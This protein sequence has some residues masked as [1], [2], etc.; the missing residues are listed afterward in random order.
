MEPGKEGDCG[1]AHR[2]NP[3]KFP[4]DLQTDKNGRGFSKMTKTLTPELWEAM[5]ELE[6]FVYHAA[7]YWQS[8]WSLDSKDAHQRYHIVFS[9]HNWWYV[10]TREAYFLAA[11]LSL[12]KFFERNAHSVNIW[13]LVETLS[14]D[15][16][17]IE[18]RKRLMILLAE[19]DLVS[20]DITLLRSNYYVHKRRNLSFKEM[21]EKTNLSYD[22][23]PALIKKMADA[24]NIIVSSLEGQQLHPG[25]IAE[26]TSKEMGK[27]L[28]DLS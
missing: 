7:S 23:V 12:A 14:K 27:L 11:I 24:L 8:Y 18:E 15:V 9:R 28:I 21:M 16:A 10:E 2:L 6:Q 3:K 19:C 26:R 13:Q 4:L 17:W 22:D 25:S 20:R 1:G 5:I